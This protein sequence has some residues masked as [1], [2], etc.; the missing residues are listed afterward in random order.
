LRIGR[1]S[2]KQATRNRELQHGDTSMTIR[3]VFGKSPPFAL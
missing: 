2:Q 3:S 1:A